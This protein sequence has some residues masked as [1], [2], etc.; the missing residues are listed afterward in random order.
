M[1]RD[2]TNYGGRSWQPFT[3][4]SEFELGQNYLNLSF[5]TWESMEIFDDGDGPIASLRRSFQIR[6][7][8]FSALKGENTQV[9]ED[10]E[11]AALS[12]VGANGTHYIDFLHLQAGTAV[13]VLSAVK[14]VLEDDR[15][16]RVKTGPEFHAIIAANLALVTNVLTLA[17]TYA[18]QDECL[19]KL[20]TI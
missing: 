7:E 10:I 2:H 15:I 3:I 16:R 12:I 18:Q 13:L 14:N 9:F 5:D 6:A 17:W 19:S 4:L 11:A 8:D 20:Q 1:A